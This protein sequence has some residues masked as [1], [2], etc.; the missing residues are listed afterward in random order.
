MHI[1]LLIAAAIF[2]RG[3]FDIFLSRGGGKIDSNISNI[4]VSIAALLAASLPYMYFKVKNVTTIPT[5][6]PGVVLSV[7]AG[8]TIGLATLLIIK[9]YESGGLTYITPIVLGGSIAFA[10]FAGTLVF[11][12]SAGFFQVL[13][14]V[15]VLVGIGIIIYAKSYGI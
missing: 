13:G 11:Q 4:I 5:T 7:C 2:F 8:L 14:I 9:A 1:F 15:V 12:E 10:T 6:L 3:L